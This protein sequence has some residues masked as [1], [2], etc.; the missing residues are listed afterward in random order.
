MI[1]QK[2]K[3]CVI[4]H[5][6]SHLQEAIELLSNYGEKF[7]ALDSFTYDKGTCQ[8]LLMSYGNNW[9]LSTTTWDYPRITLLELEMILMNDNFK[10]IIS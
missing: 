3:V 7:K 2:N 9:Y 1:P 6:E 10:P 8:Y 5:D 4:I